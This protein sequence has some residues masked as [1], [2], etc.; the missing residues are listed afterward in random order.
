MASTNY[1]IQFEA[2][3][4]EVCK[5]FGYKLVKSWEVDRG[6]PLDKAEIRDF[7]AEAVANFFSI[8]P[9]TS[10]ESEPEV[11]EELEAPAPS[12]PKKKK[13]KA[14]A[15]T[16]KP[17]TPEPKVVEE[18]E[19]PEP[20]KKGKGKA[21]AKGKGKPKCQALTAKGTPCAK[22]AVEGSTFCSVHDPS[23]GKG[24]AVATTKGKG[25]A[26]VAAKAPP[27][28]KAKGGKGKKAAAKVVETTKS[29]P[30]SVKH[31]HGLD[32][33]DY[34]NCDLCKSH[35][36]PFELPE[37]ESV[38]VKNWA[39]EAEIY[40]PKEDEADEEPEDDEDGDPDYEAA[41]VGGGPSGSGGLSEEDFD[42]D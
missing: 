37:Y 19:E 7:V 42:E 1:G 17:K 3:M 16:K 23:K 26:P 39:D 18:E 21:P 35:G 15:S 20:P 4:S 40:D 13:A 10:E 9:K 31:T 33:L 24:K 22:C 25:K 34:E 8:I 27:A 38:A 6:L 2:L 36:G 11:E 32:E 14:K 30:A 41:Y 29:V 28:S 5:D 12:P